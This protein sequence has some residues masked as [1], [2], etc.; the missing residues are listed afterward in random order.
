MKMIVVVE[1]LVL[2]WPQ[3]LRQSLLFSPWFL[4]LSILEEGKNEVN[5]PST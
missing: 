2:L 5:L 1:V 3:Q 4:L